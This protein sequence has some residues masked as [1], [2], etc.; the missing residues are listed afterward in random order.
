M[1][2]TV[3]LLSLTLSLILGLTL[4]LL[5]LSPAQAESDCPE[6]PSLTAWIMCIDKV[7]EYARLS[8]DYPARL[9]ALVKSSGINRSNAAG[10]TP[11]GLAA[12]AGLSDFVADLLMLGA[13]PDQPNARGETPL[14]QALEG[15]SAV[16]ETRPETLALL[17]AHG[18]NVKLADKLGRTPLML[19][20]GVVPGKKTET[21]KLILNRKPPVWAVDK[22]GEHVL[23]YLARSFSP[24]MQGEDWIWEDYQQATQLLLAYKP[25]LKLRNRA[26]QT[27]VQ[28]AR[29]QGFTQLAEILDVR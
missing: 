7:P 5:C 13:L 12:R 23:F 29:K 2:F 28:V 14:L 16:D 3:S 22:Q 4:G 19:A 21:L 26:G 27:V 1:K 25:N 17:L 8:D 6:S 9:R 15:F 18:V 20:A 11:L 24:A 10:D